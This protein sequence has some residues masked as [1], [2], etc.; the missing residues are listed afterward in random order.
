MSVRGNT[1][2]FRSTP[3]SSQHFITEDAALSSDRTYIKVMETVKK[4]WDSGVIQRGSG[5]CIAMSDMVYTLLRRE[6]IDCEMVECKLTVLSCNPPGLFLIGHEN[7][8][9]NP[10]VDIDTHLVVITRSDI[11]MLIDL[12]IGNLLPGQVPYIVERAGGKEPDQLAD[13]K[14]K[15]SN[16]IYQQKETTSKLPLLHQRSFVERIKTD[17]KIVKNINFLKIL[18]V[19]ALVISTVNAIRG[20]YDFYQ[21]YFL[22]NN[23]GPDTGRELTER[24]QRL[25]QLMVTPQDQRRLIPPTVDNK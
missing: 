3:G 6:G 8:V 12:S 1:V 23:W 11:P 17:N 16:W 9:N 10:Q 25:E 7:Q 2:I 21:V 19:V 24:L 13:V 14:V 4:L 22:D 18:I 15:D 20:A 5:F